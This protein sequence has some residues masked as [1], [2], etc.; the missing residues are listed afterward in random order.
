MLRVL[1]TVGLL[2]LL[3]CN[4]C[5]DDDDGSLRFGGRNGF[6]V[7]GDSIE[8]VGIYCANYSGTSTQTT[9]NGATRHF[10]RISLADTY[11]D[12]PVNVEISYYSRHAALQVG[13]YMTDRATT[14]SSMGIHLSI[15]DRN[16]RSIV[17]E[18]ADFGSVTVTN[19]G[20]RLQGRFEATLLSVEMIGKT[21]E[22]VGS[23]DV[24][25]ERE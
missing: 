22:V 15:K 4:A 23:F 24:K 10:T 9:E 8:R 13:E 14:E 18:G 25:H 12:S 11:E 19:V 1:F 16:Y 2:L 6:A 3:C 17:D 7:E 20:D 21:I 5:D